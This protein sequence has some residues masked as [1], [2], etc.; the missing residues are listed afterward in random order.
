MPPRVGPTRQL[1]LLDSTSIIVGI[2]IGSAI[3][4]SRRRWPGPCPTPPGWRPS[5][6][7]AGSCRW[8]GPSATP[9][10]PPCIRRKVAITSTSP[11][12]WADGW[13]FFSP[14]RSSGSFG[15]GRSAPLAYVFADYANQLF[16]LGAGGRAAIVYAAGSI[17]DPQRRQCSRRSRG[18]VD[19]ESA[20]RGEGRW[21]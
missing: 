1:T 18:E 3:Y 14:G 2:I 19:A 10:W 17:V 15:P 11:A 9:N 13:V 8:S 6:R 4:K 12:R 5:G 7:W 20:D 21:R 16:P